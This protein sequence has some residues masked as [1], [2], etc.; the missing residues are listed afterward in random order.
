[1]ERIVNTKTQKEVEQKKKFYRLVDKI[2]NLPK[3]N[4]L[5]QG[6][7]RQQIETIQLFLEIPKFEDAET[8]SSGSENN[9]GTGD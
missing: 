9:R 4:E 2:R 1:M 6:T 7:S 3:S 5:G 8:M